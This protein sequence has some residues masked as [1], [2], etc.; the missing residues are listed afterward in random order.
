MPSF[1]IVNKIDLQEV[2]NA[3]NNAKKQVA[4][5]YDFRDSNTEIEFDKS[6]SV[7]KASTSD[8]MKM[9]ALEDMLRGAL[10]KRGIDPKALEFGDEEG[11]SRGGVRKTIS[12]KEGIDKEMG[13]KIVKK[14][15]EQKL[16]VQAQIQD[17]QVRVTGKK[18][19]DLQTVIE[20]LK[21]A[22]LDVPLQYVNMKS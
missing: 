2:D 14:I 5:R 16:K 21:G 19:D 7:I 4:T 3:L 12:L 22:K 10:V 11:T 15:K 13:K 17:E 6:S 8:S 1:D 9:T 18:I 20:M